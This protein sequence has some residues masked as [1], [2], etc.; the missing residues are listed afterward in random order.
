MHGAL[1]RVVSSGGDAFDDS[2]AL[3]AERWRYVGKRGLSKGYKFG[4]GTPVRA[5]LVRPS[6]LKVKAKGEAL[7]HT[8]ATDPR[9]VVIELQVGDT[10]FCFE[11]GGTMGFTPDKKFTSKN[12]PAPLACPPLP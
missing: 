7:G 11:F 1:L 4:G 12:A 2:Y 6:T 3:P 8:L 9:P 10:R 5:V